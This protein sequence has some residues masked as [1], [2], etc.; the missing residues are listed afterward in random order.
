MG[1]RRKATVFSAA[2][3]RIA[4]HILFNWTNYL[5]WQATLRIF[6]EPIS[7]FAIILLVPV[8][9]TFWFRYTASRCVE[10]E[11]K[12]K[13]ITSSRWLRVILLCIPAALCVLW[14]V[15]ARSTPFHAIS[16][17]STGIDPVLLQLFSF[18]A[19]ALGTIAAVKLICYAHSRT[20]FGDRWTA[21]DLLRLAGWST[22]SPVVAI[23][24]VI[25]AFHQFYDRNLIGVVWLIAAAICFLVGQ[26]A[27]QSA[28]GFRP[29][30]I[31]SGEL[32]KRSV[33]LAK[34]MKIPLQSVS[35]VPGGRGHLT[36]GYSLSG[37]GI[38]LTDN[39]SKFLSGPELDSVIV[40]ELAHLKKR[41]SRKKLLT[42][43]SVYAGIASACFFLPPE[44]FLRFRPLCDLFVAFI[45][46]LTFYFLSRR[47]EYAADAA[48]VEFVRQPEA[49]IRSLANMYR[50]TL[51]PVDCSWPL[52]LF[53]THPSLTRR[54]RAL[55][56]LGRL[57]AERS[58]ELIQE[59]QLRRRIPE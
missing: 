22:L 32:Y 42:M 17:R 41:H 39:Y 23:L 18:W 49:T 46:L 9:L 10:S 52:E 36:N 29:R 58:S 30:K 54:T 19:P 57:S 43:A 56:K 34:E 59:A 38:A 28:T 31:K 15:E 25:A 20:I 24:L 3:G 53:M 11:R 8:A 4:L 33:V 48:S 5:A 51:S 35:V 47:F 26:I 1:E 7:A 55:E 2:Q 13:W 44:W 12:T 40:H 45:P 50:V 16:F 21:S 6:A 37:H 27:F 14:D